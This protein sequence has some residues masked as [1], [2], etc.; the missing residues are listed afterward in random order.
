MSNRE[1][2]H[3][4]ELIANGVEPTVNSAGNVVHKRGRGYV[5]LVRGNRMTP[6][7]QYYQSETGLSPAFNI[8]PDAVP[9]RIGR[10]EYIRVRGG[11]DRALRSW[12]VAKGRWNYTR[13]GRSYYDRDR[14]E[15]VVRLPT[16]VRGR[17][18]NGS[19][20][21]IRST[22]PVEIPGLRDGPSLRQE[23]LA[24][25]GG[26][27][28]KEFH[29][30]TQSDEEIFYRPGGQ[31][32]ISTLRTRAGGEIEVLLHRNL[33]QESESMLCIPRGVSTTMGWD[34]DRTCVLF[35]TIVGN[36]DWRD[37]GLQS[38]AVFT[39]AE[40]YGITACC[41]FQDQLVKLYRPAERKHRR[42]LAWT[43][44]GRRA[45]FHKSIRGLLGTLPKPKK[46]KL[47]TDRREVSLPEMEEYHGLKGGHFWHTDLS[48][49]RAELVNEGWR[50]KIT[51]AEPFVIKKLACENCVVHS[52]PEGWQAIRDWYETMGL[53]NA[54]QGLP[55]AANDALVQLL[56]QKRKHLTAAQKKKILEAQN[57]RCAE[58]LDALTEPEFDHV[59]PLSQSVTEQRCHCLC[60][61]C[62][63]VKRLASMS[64]DGNPL[65]SQFEHSVWEAYMLS[66]KVKPLVFNVHEAEGNRLAD[67]VVVDVRRCRR[68]ALISPHPSPVFSIY[69]RIE[70]IQAPGKFDLGVV[71]RTG[72]QSLYL[73]Y[74]AELG[75][76]PWETDEI[77]RGSRVLYD[78]EGEEHHGK[79]GTMMRTEYEY[80]ALSDNRIQPIK[81]YTFVRVEESDE[82]KEGDEVRRW[83]SEHHWRPGTIEGRSSDGLYDVKWH[84]YSVDEG[85]DSDDAFDQSYEWGVPR[86]HLRSR[87]GAVPLGES[88][89]LETGTVFK[90][91]RVTMDCFVKLDDGQWVS[92]PRGVFRQIHYA[93]I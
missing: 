69:D 80:Y 86:N 27:E 60:R 16:R 52:L 84:T 92:Q 4:R 66:E 59:I 82:L 87:D 50:C 47:R 29:V 8:L 63:F 20:Y 53:Q 93:Q 43:I 25:Y 49:L 58:C 72:K 24:H 56:K 57:H 23:V 85:D 12:D 17:H 39:L 90:I 26:Q 78:Y 34:L 48:T 40:E 32:Q 74:R 41:I 7:G 42:A 55:A 9:T 38:E 33:G 21:E 19:T 61:E 13:L 64:C 67:C 83:G 22:L 62:H 45:I 70:K 71:E 15:V 5:T 28:G 75:D 3:V 88:V 68:N 36:T 89:Q 76:V 79:D 44:E 10:T 73:G 18:K 30:T 81:H 91:T 35:D 65:E 6:L 11:V 54:G 14:E 77:P 51:V 46:L 31:W 2:Q 37:T 1:K